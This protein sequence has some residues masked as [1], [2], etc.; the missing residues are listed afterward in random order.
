MKTRNDEL[1]ANVANYVNNFGKIQ[2][3][4]ENEHK[5][6]VNLNKCMNVNIIMHIWPDT[7]DDYGYY[8]WCPTEK[9][10]VYFKCI[11]EICKKYPIYDNLLVGYPISIDDIFKYESCA[12]VGKAICKDLTNRIKHMPVFIGERCILPKDAGEEWLLMNAEL[13]AYG[14]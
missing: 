14:T 12:C 3:V 13:F 2:F 6:N 9:T 11:G 1:Y 5:I 10:P 7:N 8:A 4:C